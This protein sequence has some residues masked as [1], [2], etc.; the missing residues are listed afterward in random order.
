MPWNEPSNNLD[1]PRYVDIFERIN[2]VDVPRETPTLE[3]LRLPDPPQHLWRQREINYERKIKG[4][5]IM[6]NLFGKLKDWQAMLLGVLFSFCGIW[7]PFMLIGL[8]PTGFM[9]R[10]YGLPTILTGFI[11][12]VV[13]LA[14]GILLITM[15]WQTMAQ[16]AA[17]EKES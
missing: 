12:F 2:G 14:A 6:I 13:G 7:L 1:G 4:M 3:S 5:K 17:K 15:G 8:M 16:N 10:W 11:L 9:L